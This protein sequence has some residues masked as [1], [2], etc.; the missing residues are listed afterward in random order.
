MDYFAVDLSY[1]SC[2]IHNKSNQLSFS[3]CPQN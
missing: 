3:N 2:A 1:N